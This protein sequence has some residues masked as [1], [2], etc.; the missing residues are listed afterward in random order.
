[1]AGLADAVVFD[2]FDSTARG[3]RMAASITLRAA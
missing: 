3:N 2:P 1:V